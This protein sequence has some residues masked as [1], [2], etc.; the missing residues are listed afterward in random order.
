MTPKEPTSRQPRRCT[1]W[2]TAHRHRAA[3]GFYSRRSGRCARNTSGQTC[4][5]DGLLPTQPRSCRR[6]SCYRQ[7]P[8]RY[9]SL[10]VERHGPRQTRTAN[11]EEPMGRD[12]CRGHPRSWES[13]WG[14]SRRIAGCRGSTERRPPPARHGVQTRVGFGLSGRKGRGA[15]TRRGGN[16]AAS[17]RMKMKAFAFGFMTNRAR[18][19]CNQRNGVPAS[20]S[21][22]SSSQS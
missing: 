1:P 9:R 4:S 15:W 2:S 12:T 3:L 13:R 22:W 20:A 11:P 21:G 18:A 19:A 14:S 6:R 16:T 17:R 8:A 7:T 10:L 5:L